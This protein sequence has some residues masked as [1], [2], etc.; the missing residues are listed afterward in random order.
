[1]QHARFSFNL[2]SD[3]CHRHLN[4]AEIFSRSTSFENPMLFQSYTIM[5]TS[6]NAFPRLA[7]QAKRGKLNVMLHLLMPVVMLHKATKTEC[8]KFKYNHCGHE[9]NVNL[10]ILRISLNYSFSKVE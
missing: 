5:F 1:M 7:F 10:G 2:T 4:L 8:M 3:Q 9:C 6:S